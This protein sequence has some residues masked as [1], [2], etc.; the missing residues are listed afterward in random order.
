MNIHIGV[1]SVVVYSTG[2]GNAR[3]SVRGMG[4]RTIPRFFMSMYQ[5]KSLIRYHQDM[6]MINPTSDEKKMNRGNCSSLDSGCKSRTIPII[7]KSHKKDNSSIGVSTKNVHTS[8]IHWYILRTTYGREKKAYEY[9]VDHGI[10][11]FYPVIRSVRIINGRKQLIEE[12]RIPNLF[13]ARGTEEMLKTF[14]FDNINLPYLRF[15]YRHITSGS[16]IIRIPLF[17][18][19]EEMNSLQIIT[20]ADNGDT[21][22][23]AEVIKHFIQGQKVRVVNGAFAGVVGRIGRYHSQQRVAVII[24]GVL[25]ACTAYIPSAFI[26]IL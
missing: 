14:V 19:D 10:D 8:T 1:G 2:L 6:G 23:T 4:N 26:E 15:Y 18:S 11:A 21:I 24:D 17:I 25:T 9:L 7:E 12:S 22:V 3:A 13:F 5:I 16:K 20:A